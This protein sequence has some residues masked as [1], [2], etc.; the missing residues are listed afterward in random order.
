MNNPLVSIIMPC[1]NKEKYIAETLASVEAQ[2][3]SNWELVLIDDCSPDDTMGVARHYVESHHWPPENVIYL[4][5]TN[6]GPSAARNNGIQ[7]SHGKYILPL[8]PDDIIAPTYLE[9]AVA[10]LDEH[11]D[12]KLVYCEADS[13][14]AWSGPWPHREYN[15]ETLLWY[16]L[17]HNSA[18][19][20]R[21][22]YDKTL[23]YNSN[24]RH[25]LEDWDFY[26]TLL[27]PDDKVHCIDEI[28]YHWRAAA[29]QRTE[30][31]DAHQQE[32]LRQIYHNHQH[33]YESFHQDIVFFHEMWTHNEWLYHRADLVRHSH[34]YRI[35]KFIL[36][37]L[38]W[39]RQKT[40]Y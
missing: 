13:F 6:Q 23:G 27:G 37:P 1:Y 25:G 9:K 14:G 5:Q 28:L 18:I 15:H 11:P 39:I 31:A 16:N 40:K 38:T 22:D 24:M 36:K 7:H 29:E 2:T 34:A 8:D 32:L 26:L 12:I 30:E 20:R 3:Y 17:I 10:I 19:Y 4:Q 35:G 33:L 21:A